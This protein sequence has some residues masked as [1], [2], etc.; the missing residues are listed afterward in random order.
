MH[1]ERQQVLMLIEDMSGF[2]HQ[3][4]CL[5]RVGA[6]RNDLESGSKRSEDQEKQQRGRKRHDGMS[7]DRRTE[8]DRQTD[9]QTDRLHIES[10][11]SSPRPGK[12]IPGR[13]A[14]GRPQGQPGRPGRDVVNEASGEDEHL[15]KRYSP[16]E[17]AS[18]LLD[19]SG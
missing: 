12:M 8:T 4:T 2:P 19:R 7:E 6:T 16:W 15:L 13:A 14:R 18:S 3:W 17:V 5:S 1:Q 11:R 9:R 10:V